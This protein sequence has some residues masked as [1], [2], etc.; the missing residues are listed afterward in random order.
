[1]IK[2]AMKRIGKKPSAPT[3]GAL[4]MIAACVCLGVLNVAVRYISQE[5]H[6]FQIAFFRNAM[7]LLIMLPWVLSR[8]VGVLRTKRLRGHFLRSLSGLAAMLS[9]FSALALMPVAE[10]TAI[11][12]TAPLF[13]TMGAALF[14]GESVGRRRWGATAVG[15]VGAMIILRPGVGSFDGAHMLAIMAAVF[16]SASGLIIKSMSRTDAPNVIAA[17]MGMFMTILSLPFALFVWRT[18]SAHALG[19][20]AVIGILATSAQLCLNR[21]FRVADASAVVPFDF[22]RLPAAALVAYIAFGEAPDM[23]TWVGAGV[24]FT[25]GVYIARRE[26]RLHAR[27]LAIPGPAVSGIGRDRS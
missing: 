2:A 17:Y 20:A 10:A 6:P 5:L 9:W 15:F 23:W 12:F 7:Q 13:A 11:T 21:A 16:I 25:S 4:W 18:P 3:Q 14:L 8:G 19:W 22:V 24:I 27:I 1:M 26:A